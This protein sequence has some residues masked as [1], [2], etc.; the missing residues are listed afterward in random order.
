MEDKATALSRIQIKGPAALALTHVFNFHWMRQKAD[1][2]LLLP[3]FGK[4]EARKGHFW[5]S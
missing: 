5:P 3:D 1:A 2:T 4:E